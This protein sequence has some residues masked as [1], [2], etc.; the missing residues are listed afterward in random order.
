M[1]KPRMH[2]YLMANLGRALYD[3]RQI[4]LVL[5]L[6]VWSA[7][8]PLNTI[9]PVFSCPPFLYI[10]LWKTNSFGLILRNHFHYRFL[11]GRLQ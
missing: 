11:P 2:V 1:P 8:P 6:S 7:S 9:Y 5:H 10:S 3:S 4:K